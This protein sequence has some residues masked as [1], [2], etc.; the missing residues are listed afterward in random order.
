MEDNAL[1]SHVWNY[2]RDCMHPNSD[3]LV[4]NKLCFGRQSSLLALVYL[5]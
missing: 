5:V 4:L 1:L 3:N 2:S